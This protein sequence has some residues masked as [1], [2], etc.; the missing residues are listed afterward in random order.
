MGFAI[1]SHKELDAAEDM[2]IIEDGERD[3]LVAVLASVG[4]QLPDELL[5]RESSLSIPGTYELIVECRDEADQ[6]EKFEK[7]KSEGYRLRILTL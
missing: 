1:F 5:N 7:L 2:R 6:K 3:Y 4:E